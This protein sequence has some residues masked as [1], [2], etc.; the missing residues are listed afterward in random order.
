[1]RNLKQ[2][3]DNFNILND[4][5]E[6]LSQYAKIGELLHLQRDMRA[7]CVMLIFV[8]LVLSFFY[9]NLITYASQSFYMIFISDLNV[10]DQFT[11]FDLFVISLFW[12]GL[13]K[14]LRSIFRMFKKRKSY[15]ATPTNQLTQDVR[16][17][18][19]R[20]FSEYDSRKKELKDNFYLLLDDFSLYCK[21]NDITIEKMSLFKKDALVV[22][23][24]EK[25][26]MNKTLNEQQS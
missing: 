14:T 20:C 7:N 21:E 25:C 16:A 8:I 3:V 15:M 23:H 19:I 5:Q 10:T 24:L 13:F 18:Y 6:K 12:I 4:R 22:E 2:F 26:L 9:G 1:M 17:F 11:F